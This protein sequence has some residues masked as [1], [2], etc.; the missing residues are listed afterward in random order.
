MIFLGFILIFYTQF[1]VCLS[2]GLRGIDEASGGLDH[3]R[4]WG[5][6]FHRS[7]SIKT[8]WFTSESLSTYN[9]DVP[10]TR[11]PAGKYRTSSGSNLISNKGLRVDGCIP[12]PRGTYGNVEGLTTSLCSGSCPKGRYSERI[13]LTTAADSSQYQSYK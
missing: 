10:R 9:G 1:V 3:E 5:S 8:D 11:C 4:P 6:L 12:C 2:S 7:L 13:G